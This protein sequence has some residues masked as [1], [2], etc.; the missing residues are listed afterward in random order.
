M[1]FTQAHSVCLGL[2][3]K[4]IY[5]QFFLPQP[6]SVTPRA[7]LSNMKVNI[8]LWIWTLPCYQTWGVSQTPAV[9][10]ES[11]GRWSK[12]AEL[13]FSHLLSCSTVCVVLMAQE[14]GISISI[15]I[16]TEWQEQ[17][18]RAYRRAVLNYLRK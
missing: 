18:L 6:L 9:P 12:R 8:K 11:S 4:T 7:A 10:P 13:L 2:Q 15:S 17:D 16:N 1:V 3:R 14:R 5:Q